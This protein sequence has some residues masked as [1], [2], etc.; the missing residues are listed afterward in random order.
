M[1]TRRPRAAAAAGTLLLVL[2]ALPVLGLRLGMPDDGN[3]AKGTTTRVA[4]DRLAEGFGPGF[5]GPLVLAVEQR[6]GPRHRQGRSRPR[7]RASPS[8]QSR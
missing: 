1:I 2:L 6:Q 3:D 4:Y 8:S 7:R 5:N